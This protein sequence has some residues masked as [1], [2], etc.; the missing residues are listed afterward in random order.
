M[1]KEILGVGILPLHQDQEANEIQESK[2]FVGGNTPLMLNPV[3]LLLL[4][5]FPA[6][7]FD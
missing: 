6:Y 1:T 4:F 7:V 2:Y 5:D 3:Y